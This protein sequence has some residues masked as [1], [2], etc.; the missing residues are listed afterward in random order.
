[1]SEMLLL[2]EPLPAS[3]LHRL[4]VVNRLVPEGGH[5]AAAEELA[6]KLSSLPPL[7]V[8][9]NCRLIRGYWSKL[10]Q[11]GDFYTKGLQLQDSEDFRESSRAFME[12]RPPLFV[13]R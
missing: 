13:G 1:M 6:A 5:L 11:D 3:E 9:A 8:R 10:S 4:G 2:G 7:A 12:N